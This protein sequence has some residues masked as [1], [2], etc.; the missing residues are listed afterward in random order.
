MLQ[1]EKDAVK[2]L[3]MWSKK[4]D[5]AR[6]MMI[7]SDP[8]T[9]PVQVCSR[10]L[11]LVAEKTTSGSVAVTEESTRISAVKVWPYGHD[12]PYAI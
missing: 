10:L 8:P 9:L 12:L 5:W 4:F 6:Q 1:M 2:S 3:K 11:T 7:F